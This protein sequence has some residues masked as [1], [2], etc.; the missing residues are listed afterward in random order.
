MT[1][2]PN[3][4]DIFISMDL[5]LNSIT[6]KINCEVFGQRRED[7]SVKNLLFDSRK[8][9]NSDG[10]VFFAIKTLSNNG[11]KYIPELYSRGV[12][13]FV[14]EN[15]PNDISFY[16][17]ATFLLVENVIQT[18]QS[19]AKIKREVFKNP[20]IAITGSNGKTI[21][22]D[23]IVELIDKDK[24]VCHS[25][26]SYNS[27]IG[28]ALSVWNL[29]DDD[30][31][32][33]IEAGISQ[34]GE[35]ESLEE[36]IKPT[37][38]IFTNIGDAHQVY[39][40]SIEEKINEKLILFSSCKTIIYCSDKKDIHK[41][42][43]D[44]FNNKKV[45]LISWGFDE[46][47]IFKIK[48]IST[49]KN[50]STIHYIYNRKESSFTI[51]LID[52]ASIENSIN[53]Y[54]ACLVIGI[55]ENIL[56]KRTK[57]LQSLEMRL[58]MKEGING[59]LIINDSYSSD[60]MSLEVASTF[61]NQ[62]SNDLTK[63]AILSDITQ[64]FIDEK[65]LY[66]AIN[67]L[68]ISKNINF[69]IGIGNGFIR[70]KSILTIE[71]TVYSTT[72]E[73]LKKCHLK[74]FKDQ[75][76]LIKGAR[77]FEFEKIS[78][79][80]EK[81]VHE[82][83]LEV[84][85]TA[86]AHNVNYFKSKLKEGVKLMAM[87][88]AH[89]YGSGGYEIATTLVNQNVNYLTVAFADEGVELRNNGINL[90]IMVM[91]PEK[92]SIAKIIHYDLE[93][94]VYS[95]KILRELISAKEEYEKIGNTKTLS[96]H[97][98]LDT[99]MHRLGMEEGDLDTLISILNKNTDI[100]IKSIFSHLVGAD[101]PEL[102]FFTYQQIERFES[103][104]Q[105]I[106]KV[107]SYP[108]LRHIANSAAI[109][110]FPEAQYDM[111]RLGIGMY[112][113]GVNEEEQQKLRYVHRLKTIIT[114]TREIKKGESVGYNRNFIAKED[115]TI[116]VI[117][118]GYADGLNRK[119]GN[120]NGKVWINGS[121]APIIGNICMDMCMIDLTGIEFSEG[122]DVVIF[123]EEYSVNNIAKELDTIS[124]EIFTTVS[125][126]VKRVFYQE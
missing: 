89:S 13:V 73:F 106:M 102:D 64:S 39:F 120:G 28:V 67:K 99:G 59:T 50:Q 30:E 118:I 60:L 125:T 47:A 96:I 114:L 37:I 86:I 95:I 111:V 45:D 81:K 7:F 40:N 41:Q 2:R 98:K 117:P 55:D 122:D 52:K 32:G 77:S 35:M 90:P 8:L 94:E 27:Q 101:N 87:V 3:F 18:L 72:E 84:N 113:I 57:S 74:D 26:R 17:E 12:R 115:M 48:E 76:I 23:W 100:K 22:K 1:K 116:G 80:F 123:G 79:F 33:I 71:N 68:L 36:I 108:I 54:I 49:Q 109:T 6:K 75:I 34:K 21:V 19:F 15:L 126:R 119:R 58:E 43:V 121:L 38:G 124:Y 82:T 61:L 103:M 65:E 88:K 93:P 42:I 31:L 16:E 9:G 92:E 25:P 62:Q 29:K 110:R 56:K 63:T 112:G 4:A 11:E 51:P 107:F 10:T 104:S 69:L 20:I 83:V 97:V 46:D 70:N 14:V 53:A 78:R 66:T 44:K 85:L 5:L 24:K 105:R 91:S